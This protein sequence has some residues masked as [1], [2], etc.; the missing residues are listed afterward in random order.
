MVKKSEFFITIENNQPEI[1]KI[2]ITK[3]LYFQKVVIICGVIP[4]N[5]YSFSHKVN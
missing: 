2:F 1:V 3:F 4:N 5:H